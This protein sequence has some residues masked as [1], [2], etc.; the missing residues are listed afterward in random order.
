[1]VLILSM[2]KHLVSGLTCL[3]VHKLIHK[4]PNVVWTLNDISECWKHSYLLPSITS[5]LYWVLILN[6]TNF[7]YLS[8]ICAHHWTEISAFICIW[9]MLM[10]WLEEFFQ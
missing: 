2:V 7:Y 10:I 4:S 1:M 5:F 6:P 9:M 8:H 3:A